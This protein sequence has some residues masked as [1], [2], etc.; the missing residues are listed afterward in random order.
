MKKCFAQNNYNLEYKKINIRQEYNVT[1]E[2]VII[3]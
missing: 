1:I 3:I 2:G